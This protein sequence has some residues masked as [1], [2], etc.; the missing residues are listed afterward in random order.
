[1]ADLTLMLIH[2]ESSQ[3]RRRCRRASSVFHWRPSRSPV[4][5]HTVFTVLLLRFFSRKLTLLD[6]KPDSF[7]TA[8]DFAG[9]CNYVPLLFTTI[10]LAALL[11]RRACE[12][13]PSLS[14]TQAEPPLEHLALH[15]LTLAYS[16]TCVILL[17][18]TKTF[19]ALAC[20]Y[21]L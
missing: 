19:L 2:H 11:C 5:H 17:R 15:A 14:H 21:L 3:T 4:L 9:C 16:A 1:M 7:Y 12:G 6:F 18:L 8:S 13:V 10:N 20:S